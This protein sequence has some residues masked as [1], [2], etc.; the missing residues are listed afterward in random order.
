MT[1]R[2]G[3]ACSRGAP[4]PRRSRRRAAVAALLLASL[5]LASCGRGPR[6]VHVVVRGMAFDPAR[7]PVAPGDTI[8]WE[9]RD[10]VPHTATSTAG[11][12]DTGNIGPDSVA[13]TVVPAAGLGPFRCV[14]HAD[15]T[16]TLV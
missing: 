3:P 16:G 1:L 9:N 7:V 14:Y 12:W 10:I 2:T 6:T 11:R 13:R 5:A 4:A 15:M 8:V